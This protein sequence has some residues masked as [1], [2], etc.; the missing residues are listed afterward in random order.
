MESGEKEEGSEDDAADVDY[1]LAE[2]HWTTPAEQAFF[3]TQWRGGRTET[4]GGTTRTRDIHLGVRYEPNANFAASVELRHHLDAP[5]DDVS[6]SL[7]LRY[8]L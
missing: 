8:R 4:D 3:Y 1:D 7:Q 6:G 2:L 5:D